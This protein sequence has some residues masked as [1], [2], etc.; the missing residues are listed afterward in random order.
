MGRGAI[1]LGP[2]SLLRFKIKKVLSAG[3]NFLYHT[4]LCIFVFC[5]P[6]SFLSLNRPSSQVKMRK[7]ED[8]CPQMNLSCSFLSLSCFFIKNIKNHRQ[9][10]LYQYTHNK[11]SKFDKNTWRLFKLTIH[12]QHNASINNCL[13]DYWSFG[14]KIGIF[15]YNTSSNNEHWPPE[16]DWPWGIPGQ[17]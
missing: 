10:T 14:K 2:F 15:H 7:S 3:Y 6:M 8:I 5:R 9:Y 16:L 17:I 12:I 11:H 13:N 4:A 1:N